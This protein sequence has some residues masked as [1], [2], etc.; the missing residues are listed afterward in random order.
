MRDTYELCTKLQYMGKRQV[1][2]IGVFF[3]VNAQKR[4][5][6]RSDLDY[7]TN[8]NSM[9]EKRL[10]QIWRAVHVNFI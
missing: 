10:L 9:F 6:H 4:Q 7:E 3:T 1:A 2:N 8:K 5:K